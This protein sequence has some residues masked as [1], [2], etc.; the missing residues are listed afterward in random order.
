MRTR[1]GIKDVI[2]G[3]LVR[4]FRLR[5]EQSGTALNTSEEIVLFLQEEGNLVIPPKEPSVD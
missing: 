3:I 5:G 2:T 1:K 4:N